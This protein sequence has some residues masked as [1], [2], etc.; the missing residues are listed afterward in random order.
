VRMVFLVALALAVSARAETTRLFSMCPTTK[1]AIICWETDKDGEATL[2]YGPA[3]AERQKLVVKPYIAQPGAARV[4][5]KKSTPYTAQLFKAQL[6]NLKA[7]T[8]YTYQVEIGGEKSAEQSFRTA[9]Q[10]ISKLNFIIYADSR[11][12]PTVHKKIAELCAK[13][14]PAFL[15]HGGDYVINT[16]NYNDWNASFFVPGAP[17]LNKTALIPAKG[18]HEK[19][20]EEYRKVLPVPDPEKPGAFFLEY[21]DDLHILVLVDTYDKT[22][23]QWAEE[24]L[25]KSKAKWKLAIGHFPCF[26]MGGHTE[27]W[28]WDCGYTK[29]F[30]QYGVDAY[31][32]GDSHQYERFVPVTPHGKKEHV[33]TYFTTAGAGAPLYDTGRNELLAKTAKVFHYMFASIDGNTLTLKA[34]DADGKEFDS[35]VVSKNDDG[36]VTEEYR[37]TAKPEEALA[38]STCIVSHECQDGNVYP[39]IEVL[40]APDKEVKV[41]FD[42]ES[43]KVPKGDEV[44]VTVRLA[45]ESL[46]GYE[47]IPA[48]ITPD[49]KLPI[50]EYFEGKLKAKGP[51][52]KGRDGYNPPLAFE[53][54]YK[55]YRAGKLYYTGKTWTQPLK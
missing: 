19:S 5:N 10:K 18:N 46:E 23:V 25:S 20:M 52:T 4:I 39:K 55:L 6:E 11:S 17:L 38:F 29:L 27:I 15:L 51:V 44:E 50:L 42:V 36:T 43:A 40:P 9:P 49:K 45:P 8:Q 54:E 7:D 30:N 21:G 22:Y 48:A 1:S 3:G 31:F 26:N 12:N 24:K 33:V 13:H 28:G 34:I 37:K 16:S 47:L 53:C 2:F 14:E 32:G 35:H 41:L